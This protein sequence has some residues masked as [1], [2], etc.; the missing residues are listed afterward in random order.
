MPDPI[1]LAPTIVSRLKEQGANAE[2]QTIAAAIRSMSLN[3]TEV[4]ELDPGKN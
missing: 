1:S 2:A 4:S 3:D